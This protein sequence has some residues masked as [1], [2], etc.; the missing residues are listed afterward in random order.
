MNNYSN[1]VGSKTKQYYR[2]REVV[3]IVGVAQSTLYEWQRLGRFPRPALRPSK[4]LCLYS[5]DQ[6]DA[7][8]ADQQAAAQQ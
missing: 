1:S 7:W 5:S 4:R 6:I 3:Q 2:L 8:L